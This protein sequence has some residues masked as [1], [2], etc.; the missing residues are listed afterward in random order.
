[1]MKYYEKVNPK[2]PSWRPMNMYLRKHAKLKAIEKFGSL[3]Q[4]E[5]EKQRRGDVKLIKDLESVSTI[6]NSKQNREHDNSGDSDNILSSHTHKK[7]KSSS[8]SRTKSVF[9][10]LADKVLSMKKDS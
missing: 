8:T 7:N 4:L 2:N 1:M 10:G 3:D 5:I 9:R 6:F